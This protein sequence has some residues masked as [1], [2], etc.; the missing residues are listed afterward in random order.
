MIASVFVRRLKEG[1]TLDEFVAEWQ[2]D[3]GYGVPTR[4]LTAQS[5]EDPRDILSIG[6]V[7][8]EEHQLIEWLAANPAADAE[9]RERID[10]VIESTRFTGMF[11]IRTEHDF[12][13]V[14]RQIVAGTEES[15]LG[16]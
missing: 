15:L 5:I 3:K 9:R 16:R 7:D 6:L 11:V 8:V 14:P 1:R 13:D 10:T 4:V 12:T 2:A